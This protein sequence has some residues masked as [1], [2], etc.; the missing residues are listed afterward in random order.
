MGYI[1]SDF[2]KKEILLP[3]QLGWASKTRFEVQ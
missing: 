3:L 1:I 2:E